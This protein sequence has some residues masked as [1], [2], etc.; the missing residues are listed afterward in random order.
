MKGTVFDSVYFR[1][2]NRTK[3]ATIMKRF[4][5]LFLA[6]LIGGVVAVGVTKLSEQPAESTAL[7]TTT[8][9]AV[10]VVQPDVDAQVQLTR[11]LPPMPA[12]TNSF[13]DAAEASLDG[14]VHV[15]TET[16]VENSY[17][18]YDNFHDFFFGPSQHSERR[19]SMGSGSGVVISSDGYVVTNNHVI[20]K[21][22][23]IKVTF[24]NKKA[25]KATLIGTDPSTDLA[26]LKVD[27]ADI[28]YIP[29]GNSD[30]V[31]VGEWVLAVGNP[32]NLTST[33]TAGIVSAKGRDINIL[34]GDKRTGNSAVESF[35][36]T[37]AAV[38]PGNSGGALVN[39]QG[40]LVGINTAIKSNT[41]SYTGYSFA[42][43]VNIVRKVVD[44][45]LEF[46][47]VQR[48]YIGVMIRN[49]D[50]E[51]A[52][53]QG[54]DAPQGVLVTDLT[55]A[56]AARAAGIEPGDVI[57]KVG[58]IRVNDV[59]Q[60]Q[61]QVSKFRPGDKAM[62]T[63]LRDGSEKIIPVQLKNKEGSTDLVAKENTEVTSALG[64]YF[65][66]VNREEKA[67]LGLDHGLKITKLNGGKLR[68]AGIRE[69]FII[70]Q[71]DKQPVRSMNEMIEILDDKKGGV[72]IEG[73]Y[74]NGMGAYY[75]F[76]M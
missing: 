47:V 12:E 52:K 55:E 14:V 44:D 27:A 76:G 56:G 8:S 49:M 66:P 48:A 4:S 63:V 30:E 65:R 22:D 38:N 53:E 18:S 19:P 69:G 29:Y 45:L 36:Q 43:P 2:S 70:T 60:L 72:L 61:E 21:A 6:A 37:D 16:M 71:I 25:Y 15:T 68:S 13:A 23:D 62:V 51:L 24:N 1:F 42:V 35:L 5:G 34:Q 40:K 59:P 64:A 74:P 46:G 39:A 75:G 7:A 67:D 58:N 32:F 11:A 20:D 31:R 33:V 57:V 26:L 50:E 3:T 54:L 10:D 41:G 28:P 9:S 73:V 17:Y